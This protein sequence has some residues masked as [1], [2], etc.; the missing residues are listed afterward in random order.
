MYRTCAVWL[1]CALLV[2][3]AFATSVPQ[4]VYLT[5]YELTATFAGKTF[6]GA[7]QDGIGWREA[8]LSDGRVDYEDDF[9][10]AA[11]DWSVRDDW[12]C[13]FYDNGLGG[14]CFAVIRR[15]AN[16]FDFYVIDLAENR[17]AVGWAAVHDRLSWT[18]RGSRSDQPRTCPVDLAS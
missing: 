9:R 15:S 16:C 12:L 11:G 14:G 5:G 2:A 10:A 1:I 8:Y 3:P 13:T 6:R 18:A 17:P 7:Y 4:K